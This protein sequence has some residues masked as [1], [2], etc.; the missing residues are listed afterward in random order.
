MTDPGPD[1]IP[2]GSLASRLVIGAVQF[3]MPYGA[4]N[5]RGQV[6]SREVAAILHRAH[7]VGIRLVDTA[8]G[9]GTSEAV[10]GDMLPDF[11]AIDVVTKLPA[12]PGSVI[13]SADVKEMHLAIL[14]SLDL[15]RRS[16]LY[17]LLVHHSGDLSKP[18]GEHIVELL[19]RLK[20]D[21]IAER[22]GVSVY[23]I[24]DIDRIL[25][26]FHPD[27]V[28]MPINLFDQR[29]IQ[30]GHVEQLHKAGIEVHAR[31]IF[32]QGILLT[33]TS[34]LSHYFSSFAKQFANYESFLDEHGITRLAACLG[35]IMNQ[36][37]ADHVLIGVTS[38]NELNQILTALSRNETLPEMS[39]LASG[40]YELIDPRQ[41]RLAP[42]GVSQ[43]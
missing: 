43:Q 40:E 28:Q 27:I 10:L 4:T 6:P 9:Y 42:S 23:D 14:R 16:T 26:S 11:P 39:L 32:L 17:G 37:G 15:L 29:F 41:W 12:F 3:G 34:R 19:D 2:A 21:G 24:V 25:K 7:E 22:V 36:S 31:S 13:A 35:F 5:T 33:E 18:G 30:G 20:Q 38:V 8:A 1:S